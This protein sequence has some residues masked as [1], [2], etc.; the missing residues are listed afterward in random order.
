LCV[1]L[2]APFIGVH[3][4]P[5]NELFHWIVCPDVNA[6]VNPTVPPEQIV[7]LPVALAEGRTETIVAALVAEQL[8]AVFVALTV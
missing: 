6:N 2:V 7:V 4:F 3:I 5:S 8:V 1:A